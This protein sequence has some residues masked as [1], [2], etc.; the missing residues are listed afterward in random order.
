VSV[1]EVSIFIPFRNRD[2]NTDAL[3]GTPVQCLALL[4]QRRIFVRQG[5]HYLGPELLYY[6][7]RR[8]PLFAG[9]RTL[10]DCGRFDL[11]LSA[12]C[13]TGLLGNGEGDLD[14]F[15]QAG[16]LKGYKQVVDFLCRRNLGTFLIMLRAF[17]GHQH[18]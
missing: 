10:S 3:V 1:P 18:L 14:Y 4:D 2:C 13:I 8:V 7:R 15:V 17:Q 11:N 16:V 6:V 9:P 12:F 5:R